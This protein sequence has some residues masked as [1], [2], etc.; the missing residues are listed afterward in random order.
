MV[1]V[2]ERGEALTRDRLRRAFLDGQVAQQPRLHARER[3]LREAR[4]ARNFRN[5]ACACWTS[6]ANDLR[7]DRR[8]VRPYR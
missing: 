2:D 7:G 1:T 5:Q 3:V 6:V 8:G 4:L